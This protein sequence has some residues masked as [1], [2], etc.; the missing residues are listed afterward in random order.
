[1]LWLL[2]FAGS[3]CLSYVIVLASFVPTKDETTTMFAIAGGVAS[4]SCLMAWGLLWNSY[5]GQIWRTV[6]DEDY[7]VTEEDP[8]PA[9]NIWQQTGPQ[10]INRTHYKYPNLVLHDLALNC[11]N[12]DGAWKETEYVR[13]EPFQGIG[14]TQVERKYE[15]IKRDF[16]RL[17][18]MI[19]VDKRYR[20]TAKGKR[21]L[22]KHY[23]NQAI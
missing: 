10:T 21:E 19:K 4:G 13:R 23:P 3:L 20:W 15:D 5:Q 11:F 17:G 22:W 8:P 16:A 2:F 1:M 7:E 12:A 9:D 14:I 18:W 6:D